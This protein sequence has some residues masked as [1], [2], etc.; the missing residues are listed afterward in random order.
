MPKTLDVNTFLEN[1]GVI[2]DVRSPG[3]FS[4]AHIPG[5][6]SLPLFSDDE[7]ARLG[8]CYKQESQ[9]AAIDLGLDIVGPKLA[10]YIKKARSLADGKTAKVHCWRGGMRSTFVAN[11]LGSLNIPSCILEGGYKGFRNWALDILAEPPPFTVVGGLTG[12]GKTAF[13]HELRSRGEQVIDLEGLANHRGSSFGGI[14]Q[15]P[16]PSTEHFENMIA[17]ELSGFDVTKPIFIEDESR[18]VGTCKVPDGIYSAIRTSP[19]KYIEKT[20]EERLDNIEKDYGSLPIEGLVAATERLHKKLGGARTQEAVRFFQ[21]G[22]FRSAVTIVLEYYDKTYRYGFGKR[23][24]KA[25]KHT[26]CI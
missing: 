18:L 15:G 10:E 6:I 12:S 20:L 4:H 2:F 25:T 26:G 23:S 22:D 13:L 19:V 24:E 21:T 1:D 17:V 5:A 11:A 14:G 9:R 7:R 16:Q 8:T 3:E